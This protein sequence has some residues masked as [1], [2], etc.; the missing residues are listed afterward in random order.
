VRIWRWSAVFLA[1]SAVITSGI[2]ACG[3]SKCYLDCVPAPTGCHIEG[4]NES[5]DCSKASCGTIVCPASDAGDGGQGTGD[6]SGGSDGFGADARDSDAGSESSWES[7]GS[8]ESG[9]ATVAGD[10]SAGQCIA[11]SD[12]DAGEECLY[13]IGDCSAKGQCLSPNSL[14]PLCFAV[15]EYCGCD[16]TNVSGLCG[17]PYAYGPTLGRAEHCGQDDAGDA[18]TE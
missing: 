1:G 11:R 15:I 12:C 2:A 14:G 17:P 6:G 10:G 8:V 13:R 7:S 16:G 5:T 18:G 4:A 3:D 9:S